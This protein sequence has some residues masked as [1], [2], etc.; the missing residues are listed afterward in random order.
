MQG[1]ARDAHIMYKF[2]QCVAREVSS[3]RIGQEQKKAVRAPI[4]AMSA[5]ARKTVSQSPKLHDFVLWNRSENYFP[6]ETS[7][8]QGKRLV[9]IL[10]PT[11]RDH[12]VYQEVGKQFATANWHHIALKC[13]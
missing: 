7:S 8:G 10:G 11:F 3:R 6:M 2:P 12:H 4:P 13:Y 1:L 9:W 5:S